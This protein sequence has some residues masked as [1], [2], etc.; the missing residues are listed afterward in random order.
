MKLKSLIARELEDRELDLAVVNLQA[1][2]DRIVSLE[3]ELKEARRE[4]AEL[5]FSM[6]DSSKKEE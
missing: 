6:P 4:I 1:L 5:H 3:F 2:V